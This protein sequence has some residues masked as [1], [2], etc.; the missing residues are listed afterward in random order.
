MNRNDYYNEANEYSNYEGSEAGYSGEEAGYF[1]QGGAEACLQNVIEPLA[2]T[3][4]FVITNANVGGTATAILFAGNINPLVQPAGVTVNVQETGG[5]AG[6][7][8]EVRNETLGNPFVIQGLRY[9]VSNA[10]QFQNALTVQ[11]RFTT[12]KLIQYLWQPTNYI[13]PTNLNPLVLDS[14]DFGAVVD[15]KTQI[16]VPV[17]G[18]TAL[19]ANSITI[20][21]TVKAA[22]S[23]SHAI[24][25]RAIAERSTAPRMTGNPI[26]DIQL[27]KPRQLR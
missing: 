16:Q 7:H 13:S 15:G 9:F 17:F 20:T 23:Q 5:G 24:F 14:P 21:F 18:G 12:G 1:A 6:S 26:A 11:K 19:V 8:D 10:N 3:Y 4:T 27:A 25:G 22:M 2:R